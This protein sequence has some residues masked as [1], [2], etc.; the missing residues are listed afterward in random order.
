MNYITDCDVI[1]FTKE[2]FNT[3]FANV[4][5]ACIELAE[6]SVKFYGDV[7]GYDLNDDIIWDKADEIV[8]NRTD[9][10][11]DIFDKLLHG[12]YKIEV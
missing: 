3:M 9:I 1:S 5:S 7:L 2:E 6:I 12:E 10:P 8:M 11:S 4:L